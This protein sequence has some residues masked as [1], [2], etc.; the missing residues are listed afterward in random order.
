MKD[1]IEK[2]QKLFARHQEV[3]LVYLFG[4]Q[5]ESKAGLLSD[6]DFAVY[7]DEKTSSSRKTDILLKLNGELLSVLKVNNVDVV[8]LNDNVGSL[9]K[10]NAMRYGK[11]IYEIEPYR[12]IVEPRIYNEYFDFQVFAKHHNL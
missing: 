7:I 5:A 4:S 3:K 8:L 6:Y 2:L 1:Y 9:L 11:L 10:Y 12:L